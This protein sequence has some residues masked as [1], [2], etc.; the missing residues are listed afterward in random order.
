MRRPTVTP[1][2]GLRALSRRAST[3][4]A[5]T[6]IPEKPSLEGLEAKWRARWEADGTYRFDRTKTR[7]E[8]FSIDT[9][10]PTVSG[11]LH[12]G[13]VIQLHA[14]R[15]HRPLPAHA[16]QGGLLP[17]GVGRQRPQRRAPRPARHRHDRRPHP[18]LRPRLPAPREGRPEGPRHPGQ[19][20][21]L[22]RAV[23]GGRARSSRRST[24]SS[25]PPS[26]LSVDW[27]HTYTSI[28]PKAART[29]QRGFLRLVAARPRLP[30]RVA[31][32]VGRRH[33]HVGGP[34]RARRPRDRRGVPQAR[35]HRPRRPAARSTPPGPSCCPPAWRS[36][37]TPTTSATSRC[38]AS[39]PSRR[40]SARP[41]RSSP[42]SWP[43][44]RRAP[45]SAMICTF[46][47][48]TDVTWWRELSLPV[49]AIVQRDGRL[50]PITWG[51]PGWEST[52]PAAAQAAYD[53]LAGKTVKQAQTRI[54]E[55]LTD[56]RAH[57]G[58][59]P[60]DHPPGEVLGERHPPARDRHQP[61]VVHPLPAQGRD[62]GPGQGA[63]LVA[64][65]HA[66]PL[67]ELGE[68]PHRRLEHHPPAVLRRAVPGLVPD[69][70]R[71]R[72]RLPVADPRRRGRAA[73]RP[74]HRG[75]RPA[76]TS[77]SATSPAASPPTPT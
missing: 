35:V 44:P 10:P 57:R 37:P 76:T 65:L 6:T 61:A 70:R 19:P 21:Q 49:R 9:P 71:R 1:R 39:R 55:L 52:D 68:R 50:R 69:R 29:S 67:R 73:H 56:G 28:G 75:A 45:A 20:A 11:S 13:H 3:L 25:G 74:H 14:H 51:E 59:D 40:C 30:Q 22:H 34:G 46:G 26:G 12:I 31:D 4:R 64:R 8:V 62:A 63:G 66:G 38:S 7:A 33:A 2:I 54:V 5:V 41:S 15:P 77:R 18:P 24:T 36:S 23:R 60:A 16:R 58:R 27:D 47:D 48:T 53:E 42:T 72:H 17:D 43:T 32:A